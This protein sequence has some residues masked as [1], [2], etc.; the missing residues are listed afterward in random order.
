MCAKQPFRTER[1]LQIPRNI[2][3]HDA[4]VAAYEQQQLEQL[5]ALVVQRCLPP[6]L[7]DQ[8]GHEH[9]DLAIGVIVLYLQNVFDQRHQDEAVWRR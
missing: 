8:L 6:V 5:S 2:D 1:Y 9:G 4:L 3:D 7:Y